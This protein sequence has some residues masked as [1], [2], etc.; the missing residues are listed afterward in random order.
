LHKAI[1]SLGLR[2]SEGDTCLFIGENL[3]FVQYVIDIIFVAMSKMVVD[4]F[5][6]GL[7]ALGLELTKEDSLCEYLGIK[8]EHDF[9][10]GM[11]TLMQG[12]QIDKI[13]EATPSTQSAIQLTYLVRCL[14]L[15]QI[16]IE[17]QCPKI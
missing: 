16:R 14:C 6:D 1:L 17:N 4:L 11:F 8:F 2:Q 10:Q 7:C 9:E 5:I 12:G 13:L 15:A 3:F